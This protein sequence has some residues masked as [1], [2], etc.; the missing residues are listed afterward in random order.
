MLFLAVLFLPNPSTRFAVVL[1]RPRPGFPVPLMTAAEAEAGVRPHACS[2][3]PGSLLS[4]VSP[5]GR[6][7]PV[8]A[9]RPGAPCLSSPSLAVSLCH[10]H[11]AHGDSE[12]GLTSVSSPVCRPSRVTGL[13]SHSGGSKATLYLLA[14]GQI[15]LP[16]FYT[17]HVA[18]ATDT[19]MF[20]YCVF[21]THFT[22]R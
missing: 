11:G 14:C 20:G 18:I 6:P 9:A 5:S 21:V 22:I 3:V 15:F 10:P 8:L 13:T 16:T 19:G 12:R 7:Q 4:V 17:L 1:T 2:L